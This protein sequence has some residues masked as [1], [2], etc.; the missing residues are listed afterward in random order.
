MYGAAA[1]ALF[2]VVIFWWQPWAAYPA[3]IQSPPAWP[4]LG[5][6]AGMVLFLC[7]RP[8]VARALFT[9]TGVAAALLI[10]TIDPSTSFDPYIAMISGLAA[11]H[12]SMALFVVAALFASVGEAAAPR[13][14]G[15]AGVATVAG[16]FA[17]FGLHGLT[18]YRMLGFRL[19]Q[20]RGGYGAWDEGLLWGGFTHREQ[21]VPV[22]LIPVAAAVIWGLMWA[23][24][25]RLAAKLATT[26]LPWL[27]FWLV[28]VLRD[29]VLPG[30]LG[31][32]RIW[33]DGNRLNE[34]WVDYSTPLDL[35][36]RLV[37][38]IVLLLSCLAFVLA[39]ARVTSRYRAPAGILLDEKLELA[40]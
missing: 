23:R 31:N 5:W 6:I 26:A 29:D 22:M 2:D 39:T 18:S 37:L 33:R 32:Y 20:E 34:G 8:R 35:W 11:W 40:A 38:A 9:A 19:D 27:V 30:G 28:H 16:A 24:R 10:L 4:D 25:H 15:L 1:F 12:T 21:V 36:V 17:I 3:S 7:G 14:P 13:R